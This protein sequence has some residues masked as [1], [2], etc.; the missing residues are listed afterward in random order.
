M[1]I[2]L[3]CL[4]FK[5]K[6]SIE[7]LELFSKI[8]RKGNTPHETWNVGERPISMGSFILI[9]S[10]DQHDSDLVRVLREH[11]VKNLEQV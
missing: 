2:F 4:K 7:K 1:D 5:H 3:K 9:F 8:L 11:Q 6:K 10:H